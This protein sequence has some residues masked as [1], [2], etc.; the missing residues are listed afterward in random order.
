MKPPVYLVIYR[1]GPKAPTRYFG[2]FVSVG[3]ADDF[4]AALP[5]P[6]E[7]GMAKYVST[8]PF[9]AHEANRIADLLLAE[10]VKI[11]A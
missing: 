9:T 6:K 7:G 5:E 11:A 10:R 1:D 4:I 2:P 8:Q 3:I